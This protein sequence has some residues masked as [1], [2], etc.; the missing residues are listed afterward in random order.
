MDV[1]SRLY[2]DTGFLRD[3]HGMEVRL[4]PPPRIGS[5]GPCLLTRDVA[6]VQA[7]EVAK[8]HAA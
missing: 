2:C 3:L 4:P 6:N 7:A 8:K 5:V 1:V